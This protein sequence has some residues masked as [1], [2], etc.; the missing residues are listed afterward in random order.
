M[1]PLSETWKKKTVFIFLSLLLIIALYVTWYIF[2]SA[3][4]GQLIEESKLCV[5][6][7]QVSDYKDGRPEN[8]WSIRYYSQEEKSYLYKN[9]TRIRETK[10]SGQQE[11]LTFRPESIKAQG[12]NSLTDCATESEY[13]FECE[14]STAESYLA[15][16]LQEGDVLLQKILTSDSME[17]YIQSREKGVIRAVFMDLSYGDFNVSKGIFFYGVLKQ[18]PQ[19]PT[20]ESYFKED[21]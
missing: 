13:R 17:C 10:E 3:N 8:V 14:L 18:E 12:L 21:L 1:K 16:T 4:H 2:Y 15:S 9:E 19:L 6:T 5:V 7:K 11:I 20:A